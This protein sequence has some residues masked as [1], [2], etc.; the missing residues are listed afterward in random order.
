MV[1][2]ELLSSDLENFRK[3]VEVK[4][5]TPKSLMGIPLSLSPL[6]NPSF[7]VNEMYKTDRESFINLVGTVTD[8]LFERI[9]LE[10][11]RESM[12][13]ERAFLEEIITHLWLKKVS[14]EGKNGIVKLLKAVINPPIDIIGIMKPADFLSDERRRK[15]ARRLNR[16]LVGAES[17]W[18]EGESIKTVLDEILKY[19]NKTPIIIFNLSH[20]DTFEE[21]NLVVS[22]VAYTIY[23][24]MR[25]K[26]E[27]S[28]PRL[29][30][31]IDEI[32]KVYEHYTTQGKNKREATVLQKENEKQ[33]LAS[34]LE[35]LRAQ[36]AN[37]DVEIKEK[38]RSLLSIEGKFQ[39]GLVD[40]DCK[41][42]ANDMA[43][44]KILAGINKVKNGIITN[45][46]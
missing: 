21:R 4:I 20:L 26:I 16:L 3:K 27:S 35:T 14:L 39:P 19:K 34:N 25:K 28:G 42:M 1:R 32:G 36:M 22:Q 6:A 12:V 43:K 17:L 37:I 11:E 38:E 5:Y 29:L 41:L 31:Y 7:D 10:S 40:I 8:S 23:S 9:F 46:K 30:F 24:W 33:Q 44:N 13:E 45:L 18:Y 15:M 2:S